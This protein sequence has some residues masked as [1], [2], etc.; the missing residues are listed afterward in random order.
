MDTESQD[1][2]SVFCEAYIL[3]HREKWPTTEHELA[4]AF[5]SHFDIP[6]V[7]Q[8]ADLENFLARTNI[9]LIEG[10]SA[11]DL[12]AS[13]CLLELRDKSSPPKT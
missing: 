12:L 7:F 6:M 3:Q 13:I 9:E 1:Q 4:L 5:V 11:P 2:L 8:V 10:D